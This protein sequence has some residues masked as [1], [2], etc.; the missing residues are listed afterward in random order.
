MCRFWVDDPSAF[1][2]NDIHELVR[3]VAGDLVENVEL[4][5]TFSRNGRESLCFRI[6]FRSMERNLTH[7]E[8]NSIFKQFREQ[9]AAKL[10]VELR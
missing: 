6:T 2:V 8:I 1:H 9:L 3:L 4:V 10:P 5:D 7:V